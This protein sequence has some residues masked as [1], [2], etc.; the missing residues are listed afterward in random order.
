MNSE[1]FYLRFAT[2]ENA[3]WQGGCAY[4]LIFGNQQN[5]KTLNTESQY[6]GDLYNLLKEKREETS[7][8]YL[9]MANP[10]SWGGFTKL[11]IVSGYDF[12][13]EQIIKSENRIIA[14][15]LRTWQGT[16]V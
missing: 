15:T 16:Q 7:R 3:D 1:R 8:F 9:D 6:R 10:Y 5:Y 12:R 4:V 2:Q 13:A 14:T 11:D